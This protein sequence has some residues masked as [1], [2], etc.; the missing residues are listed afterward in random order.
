MCPGAE[1][2]RMS[3]MQT[4]IHEIADGVYRLSTLLPEV[5]PGGFAFN[6]YLIAGDEPMLF[7]TG[8]RQLFPLVS[9]AVGKV[10]DTGSLRWLSFGHVESDECGAM[11]LWL[12]AA[13]Q[14]E[15]T[16]NGLGC[17]VSLND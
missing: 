7:H 9:E 4:N 16:F 13:P 11:N 1:E 14:S 6:Q 2:R 8:A 3:D 12:E 15:V 5:A 10:I 17:M